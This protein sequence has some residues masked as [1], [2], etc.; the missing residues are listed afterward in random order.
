MYEAYYQEK[1]TIPLATA[2]GRVAGQQLIP[3]PP[4]VPVV[5]PGERITE[6]LIQKLTELQEQGIDIVGM[7][8]PERACV[9]VLR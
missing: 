5:L 7:I 1:E 4:G 3:Y 9:E 8:G 6:P 2:A